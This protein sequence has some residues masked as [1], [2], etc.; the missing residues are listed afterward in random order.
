MASTTAQKMAYGVWTLLGS[1]SYSDPK[2]S[3]PRVLKA[4]DDATTIVHSELPG[5][6]G[7]NTAFIALVAGTQDYTLSESEPW[8]L[9][10][11]QLQT[12]GLP[13]ARIPLGAL[14]A[15]RLLNP[16]S[17]GDPIVIAFEE[18]ASGV[19]TA[20]VW[21]KPVRNDTLE[22]VRSTNTTSTFQ[23][24]SDS[25]LTTI[26]FDFGLYG[27]KVIEMV[28]ANLLMP[29]P[30]WSLTNPQSTASRLLYREAC[31]LAS[32]AAGDGELPLAPGV[33]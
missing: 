33:E 2:F 31:R 24:M 16:T 9:E 26:M 1:F 14:M 5:R 20:R 3:L 11:F 22:A 4:L 30:D 12:A 32:Y 23:G 13:V 6:Q 7:L 17:T 15:Y 19:V 8:S 21:P 18:A 28:A 25:D 27:A 29:N 10:E